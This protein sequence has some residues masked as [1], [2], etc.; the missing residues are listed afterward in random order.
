MRGI[1]GRPGWFWLFVSLLFLPHS[2]S[3]TKLT[4]VFAF[5]L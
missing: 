3:R 1:A 4:R 5:Y 2:L